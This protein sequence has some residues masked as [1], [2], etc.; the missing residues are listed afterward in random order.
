M[1]F[2]RNADGSI[3]VG[4]IPEVKEEKIKPMAVEKAKETKP[5]KSAKKSK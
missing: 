5:K 3:T 2:I 1:A 4:V